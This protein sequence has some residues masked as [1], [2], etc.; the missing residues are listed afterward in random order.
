[1]SKHIFSE[2]D[3]CDL[4]GAYIN[5]PEASKPCTGP[6]QIRTVCA[7]PT[8]SAAAKQAAEKLW[9]DSIN[10][11]RALN[12][13]TVVIIIQAAIDQALAAQAK[14]TAEDVADMMLDGERIADLVRQ[15]KERD[16]ELRRIQHKHDCGCEICSMSTGVCPA[17]SSSYAMEILALHK[18]NQ[19]LTEELRLARERLCNIGLSP[20]HYDTLPKAVDAAVRMVQTLRDTIH[21]PPCDL[22]QSVIEK[23][24]L[25]SRDALISRD[26]QIADLTRDKERLASE[27]AVAKRFEQLWK[28]RSE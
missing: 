8:P 26:Q 23:L 25:V 28:R 10:D 18:Q 9:L 20:T 11:F 5:S 12:K 7:P 2:Y 19:A 4:C 27:L 13:L 3:E 17:T 6:V 14:S 21:D 22:Q 15:L 1:M 24:D 16:E